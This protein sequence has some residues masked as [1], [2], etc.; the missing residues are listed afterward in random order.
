[1]SES[2]GSLTSAARARM[3]SR[4]IF[5]RGA[6]TTSGLVL[7]AACAPAA[8]S[9]PTAAP[10]KPA[11]AS[12]PAPPAASPASSPAAKP[13]ASPSASPAAAAAQSAPAVAKPTGPAKKVRV[14]L[15]GYFLPL[16][17]VP[18]AAYKGYYKEEGIDAE[19]SIAPSLQGPQG[20]IAGN[21]DV[22]AG[23]AT[24]LAVMAEKG[25]TMIAIATVEPVIVQSLVVRADV[26]DRIGV[27]PTDPLEKRLQAMKGLTLSVTGIGGAADTTL[28]MMLSQA[29]LQQTDINKIPISTQGG[30]LAAMDQGQID[31]IVAGPTLSDQ[32]DFDKKALILV[33]A[34][35]IPALRSAIYEVVYGL[36]S[37][38]DAHPDESRGVARAMAKANKFLKED[39]GAAKLLAENDWK[40]TPEQYIK[41]SLDK[42]KNYIPADAKMS[43]KEWDGVKEYATAVGYLTKPINLTEGTYWTNKYLE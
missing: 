13:G 4:R 34:E 31:G 21:L 8:P 16:A 37:W 30:Q 33:P 32:L 18:V 23:G 9:S 17:S 22:M 7:L 43:Q 3:I 24:D 12:K 5:L 10:S 1:M 27:K 29:K 38:V 20:L 14:G 36:K 25:E 42:F 39:P 26:L 11:E 6:V 41:L 19:I 2:P 15:A 35:E 40:T 28:S